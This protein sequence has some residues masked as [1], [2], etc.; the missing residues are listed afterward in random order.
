MVR[1]LLS[2]I[3]REAL[4]VCISDLKWMNAHKVVC[5]VDRVA[6]ED[7]PVSEWRDAYVYLLGE[8]PDE[9][10]SVLEVRSRL[11]QKLSRRGEV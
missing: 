8:E 4:P 10:L 2:D 7:Y 1:E 6:A 11:V 9:G 5:A 3:A